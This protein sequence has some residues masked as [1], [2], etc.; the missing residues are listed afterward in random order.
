MSLNVLL[1]GVGQCGN[2][3]LD[4]INKQAY[5]G[6]KLSKYFSRQKFPSNV[7]TLAVNTSRNDLRELDFTK[8]KD[9]VH[10]PHLHGVGANRDQGKKCF[11]QNKNVIFEAIEKEDDYDLGFVITSAGGGTG[12]SFS[13]LL[14]EELRER[15]NFQIHSVVVLPFRTEGT[16]FLQNTAFTLRELKE[17]DVDSMILVD[18]EFLKKGTNED[19]H[20]AYSRINSMVAQ[21]M[22]F[23]LRAL[24]SEM[25][26]V[27]DL[28]DFN[29]V[30]SAGE[31]FATLGFCNA[32]ENTAIQ[33]AIKSSLS[34]NGL[35]FNTDVYKEAGRA[36]ITIQG[37]KEQLDMEG[38]TSEVDKLSDEIGH[39]FKGIVVNDGNP[40][41]LSVLSLDRSKEL[42]SVYSKAIE[43]IEIEKRRKELK[44]ESEEVY[45]KIDGLEPEY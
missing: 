18:N 43:A 4:E 34:P 31:K 24:D 33:S 11:Q 14:V 41:V 13:P 8:A 10:T 45:S 2:R 25:M 5:G 12:S 27:T 6:G 21:R 1:L 20:T 3:I 19:I 29:T 36:M 7:R 28:G 35:L 16:I 15:Y 26:L 42:D 23:L 40:K 44:K 39:V 38:I 17:K 22:L 32:G 30:M 37:E 9:R